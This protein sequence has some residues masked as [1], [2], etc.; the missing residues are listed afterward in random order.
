MRNIFNYFFDVY[1]LFRLDLRENT[2]INNLVLAKGYSTILIDSIDNVY[3]DSLVSLW[4]K[5][6]N[7]SRSK[8]VDKVTSI[9]QRGDVCIAATYEGKLVGMCWSGEQAAI[10]SIPFASMLKNEKSVGIGHNHYVDPEHS[11]KKL[12]RIL[13][14][15]TLR[16]A[17]NTG[18][19][20]YYVFVG[21]RNMVSTINLVKVFPELKV[22][23]HLKI[24]IPF[25]VF[26]I[27]PGLS[28]EKWSKR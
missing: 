5:A 28:R 23:Y 21:I 17:Q 22:V 26:N 3:F 7:K 27:Y 4:E 18:L 1:Y 19:K 20:T 8:A 14:I 15:E 10:N 2:I 9:I 13:T 25:F 16:Y 12:Q 11:G 24:D 6:Y